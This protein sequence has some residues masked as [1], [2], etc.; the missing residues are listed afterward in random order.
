MCN[1]RRCIS[2]WMLLSAGL[3]AVLGAKVA[4]APA[5]EDSPAPK[6]PDA[7]AQ[8]RRLGRGVNIIG[9]DP[10]WRD[11]ARA[12]FQNEHFRL[13]RA[14]GFNNVRIVL[15]PFQYGKADKDHKLGDAWFATLDW[16]VEQALA[17]KLMVILDFHEFQEMA[18]APQDHKDR[19]LAMWKQIARRYKDAP[20]ELLFE[21]LNEPNGKLTPELWNQY[22]REALA[23]MRAT[24]PARTIIIGPGTWNNINSLEKLDLPEDDRNIIVTVHYYSPFPFTHQGA[25]WAGL[26]DKVGVSWNGTPAE[27]AAVTKDFEK[28]QAWAKKHNRPIFLGEFGAYDKGEMPSRV[29]WTSF[30]TREAEKLG[31]SWAYWQF[32]SDFIVYDIPGKKWIEPIRDALIPAKK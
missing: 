25:P 20:S 9:Y 17:N 31:W 22:L 19:F 10:L 23:I 30:V 26:R 8:N 7:F 27:Q 12:R 3:V 28:A 21:I 14:A 16:A 6:A 24:N 18:R 13:I 32:D 11:R 2:F 1:R 29:R 4:S 5:A 15:H